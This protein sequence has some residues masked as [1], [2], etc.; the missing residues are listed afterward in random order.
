M[1]ASHSVLGH[2]EAE[3]VTQDAGVVDD[4][5]EP[6]EGLDRLVDQRRAPAQVEMSSVLAAAWPPAATISSTTC[7]AGP[8]S[9]PLPSAAPPRS[10]TTT[11]APSAASSS[12][13]PRRCRDL[14]R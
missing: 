9:A 8:L 7:W 2:V 13:S 3:P 12:A 1:T 14:R 4:H 6:A 5:V 10:L 11:A